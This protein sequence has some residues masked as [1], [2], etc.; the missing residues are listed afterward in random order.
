VKSE[1]KVKNKGGTAMKILLVDD[2]KL[3]RELTS[4]TLVQA[5]HHVTV[6]SD[7]GEGVN[8]AREG[9]FDLLITDMFMPVKEGLEVIEEVR[10]IHPAIKVIAISIDG[11]HGA[12]T[13]LKVS[14][15]FGA[16]VCLEKPFTPEQLLEKVVEVTAA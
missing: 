14:K 13:F 4:K 15:A 8:K 10:A 12:S 1:A 3:L 7:G 6:A 11:P 9:K 16:Q 5:G 2:D